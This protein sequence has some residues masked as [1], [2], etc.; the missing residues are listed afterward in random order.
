MK[1][2]NLRLTLASIART[3]NSRTLPANSTSKIFKKDEAGNQ[4]DELD[5]YSVNCSTYRGDNINIK[6]GLNVAEKIEKLNKELENDV[7][8]EISFTGLKLT[9]YAMKSNTGNVLSGVSGKADDFEIAF[10]DNDA[11]IDI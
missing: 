1:L 3:T 2:K 4:T 11:L 8:I 9:P 10:I 7:N 5:G 6:F